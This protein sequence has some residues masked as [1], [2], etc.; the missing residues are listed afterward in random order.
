MK[1][2]R[3]VLFFG[4]SVFALL[5]AGCAPGGA[6]STAIGTLESDSLTGSPSPVETDGVEAAATDVVSTDAVTETATAVA[7]A[8]QQ[9]P[10]VPVTGEDIR[11]LENLFCIDSMAYAILII[12]TTTTFEIVDPDPPPLEAG[13]NSVDTFEDHQVVLCRAPENSSLILDVCTEDGTCT[14]LTVE[15]EACPDIVT[16][17]TPQPGVATNTPTPAA[18]PGAGT[19]TITPTP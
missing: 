9:T 10:L 8:T 16:T 6:T 17:T 14:Q 15:M 11:L 19:P 18:S 1:K 12:P 7:V 2:I 5:M 4:V 3:R 13:C